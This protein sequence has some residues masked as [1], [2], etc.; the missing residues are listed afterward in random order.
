MRAQIIFFVILS[1]T[2][3]TEMTAQPTSIRDRLDFDLGLGFLALAPDQF[4]REPCGSLFGISGEV[5]AGLAITRTI[6]AESSVSASVMRPAT[7]EFVILPAPTDGSLTRRVFSEGISG[8]PF[9]TTAHRLVFDPASLKDLGPRVSIGGG[10][11]WGKG[12]WFWSLG[13]GLRV[14]VGKASTMIEVERFGFRLP[15]V[16]ETT[17]WS[18][19]EVIAVDAS[20]RMNL[21]ESIWAFRFRIPVF[22]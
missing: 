5:G 18:G 6:L 8:N 7:C 22:R 2:L 14:P 1:L 15:F 21:R 10:R 19:G 12:V 3:V 11:F 13:V 16:E 20:A 9:L 17:V 4:E